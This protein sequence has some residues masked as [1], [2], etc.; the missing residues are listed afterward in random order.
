[1]TPGAY[2]MPGG[3]PISITRQR[4]SKSRLRIRWDYPTYRVERRQVE[5][6]ETVSVA[7]DRALPREQAF[8]YV[9]GEDRR[10]LLVLREC[11]NCAGSEVA[12][13]SRTQENDRTILLTRWFHCVKLPQD[14]LRA[15]HPFR[16][17]FPEKDIPHLFLA[18]WDGSGYV[19]LSGAQSQPDLWKAMDAVLG[20]EYAGDTQ[21]AAKE[22]LKLLA[23]YDHLDMRAMELEE[24][25]DAEIE[26]N[27]PDTAKARNLRKELEKIRNQREEALAKEQDITDIDL[28]P[29]PVEPAAPAGAR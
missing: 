24:Q 8:R 6:W 11:A 21:T 10:P 25:L 16:N 5:D 2:G 15:D 13:L 27:G 3:A 7:V 4:T 26:R 18:A 28:K 20:T 12:L 29:D 9:A 1:M 19:A 22:L 17:L 23:H 14:V